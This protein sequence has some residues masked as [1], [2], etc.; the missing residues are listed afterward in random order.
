MPHPDI[1][2]GRLCRQAAFSRGVVQQ[3]AI[4]ALRHEMPA[5]IAHLLVTALRASRPLWLV[6]FSSQ[7]FSSSRAGHAIITLE[8]IIIRSRVD[9]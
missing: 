5:C 1:G 7:Q 2:P 4:L 6:V 8:R 3:V 9:V